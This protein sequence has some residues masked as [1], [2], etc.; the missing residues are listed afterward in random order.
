MRYGTLIFAFTLV[1]SGSTSPLTAT[2]VCPSDPRWLGGQ[3]LPRA[4]QFAQPR[5]LHVEMLFV[6]DRKLATFFYD[7]STLLRKAKEIT[8]LAGILLLDIDVTL[9]VLDIIVVPESFYLGTPWRGLD[10]YCLDVNKTIHEEYSDKYKYDGAMLL[11][12]YEYGPSG[13]FVLGGI[14]NHDRIGGL[15]WVKE[16]SVLDDRALSELLAHEIGHGLGLQHDTQDKSGCDCR[17]CIMAPTHRVNYNSWW[18]DCSKRDIK[19][20]PDACLLCGNGIVE[21]GEDCDCGSNFEKCPCCDRR[22]CK[23]VDRDSSCGEDEDESCNLGGFCDGQHFDR[24]ESSPRPNGT[25]CSNGRRS[26]NCYSGIC[27]IALMS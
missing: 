5:S 20:Q 6:C 4:L 3:Y 27:K 16:N 23:L 11:S 12:G 7:E 25:S 24:C 8:R 22:T 15:F 1:V 26:G 21:N 19:R 13:A 10:R 18:S 14:C 9:V 2:Q 17:H